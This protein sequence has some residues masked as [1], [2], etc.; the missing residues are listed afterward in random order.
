MRS[1]G[2]TPAT[3]PSSS[4]CSIA[5][6]CGTR[7]RAAGWAGSGSAASSRSSTGCSGATPAR[8]IR[9]CSSDPSR[10]PRV[11]FVVTLDAD[12]QMPR[13]TVGRLVGTLAHPL[14]QPRFDPGPRRVV[15]GYGVLQP[16]VSFHLTAATHSHFAALLAASGGIDPYS[17]AASDAY[18][19]LF[20]LGSFTGKGIYDARRVRGGDRRDLP[21]EPHPQPRPDRGQLRAVRAAQRHRALRRFPRPLSRLRA[22]RAPLGSR[23]LAAASLARP[24][25][26]D[27]RRPTR[28]IPCRRS[29]DGS[30]ST[31]SAAAWCPP[32]WWC[33]WSW[34]GPS[35]PGSP[36]LWTAT[37]LAV[38]ALP[39]I[40]WSMSVVAG[41]ARTGSLAGLKSWRESLPAL[42]GQALLSVVFLADQARSMCDAIAR[43]LVRL[44]VTRRKLLEWETAASTEQRLGTGLR[45]FPLGDVAVAGSRP[46]RSPCLSRCCG[47]PRSGRRCRSWPPGSSRRWS[48]SG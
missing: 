18:M 22:A 30:S 1:T 33:S 27:A 48:H 5:A 23:R 41:C 9:S 7:R 17:T 14:N 35:C 8:A 28:R 34:A 16:R 2:G 37:A 12:T 32:P 43:T 29:S 11:R 42:G 36:W 46:S 26:A 47:P 39:L 45:R 21:R 13:D 6:G 24:A 31:I 19:D 3:A 40:K 38:L 44:L 4:S 25:G 20:G 10:L 15:E